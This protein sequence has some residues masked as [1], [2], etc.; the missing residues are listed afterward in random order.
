MGSMDLPIKINTPETNL[1]NLTF[2]IGSVDGISRWAAGLPMANTGESARQLYFAIGEINQWAA[3]PDLRM[4]V[5]EVLRP[6]IYSICTQLG[7]HFLQSSISL[8]Q[9]QVKI[10]KLAQ[11]LLTQLTTG[12]KLVVARGI[13]LSKQTN[14][15]LKFMPLAVHR[16]MTDLSQSILVN[17]QLYLRA[18]ETAWLELNQLYL[19]AEAN[20]WLDN[21]IID[22]QT[23]YLSSTTIRSAFIRAHL[24]AAAKP[25]N[26]RQQD[27]NH[28]FNALEL[29][30][31]LCKIEPADSEDSLFIVNLYRDRPATF[32]Q[33]LTDDQKALFRGINTK[34]LVIALK[35][36]LAD[37]QEEIGITIPKLMNENLINHVIHSWGVHAQRSFRRTDSSGPLKLCLGLMSI[38]YH[39]AKENNFEKVLMSLQV[40]HSFEQEDYSSSPNFSGPDD[41]WGQAFDSGPSTVVAGARLDF[42]S[43]RETAASESSKYPVFQAAINNSSPGGYSVTWQGEPPTTL[44]AGE[45]LGVQEPRVKHWAIGVVRWIS[46]SNNQETKLG[47]ELLSP[48]AEAGAIQ[49][50]QKTGRNGAMLRTLMLPEIKAIAQPASILAPHLPFKT[51]NKVNLLFD[52]LH[53][54]FQLIK[55]LASTNSFNQFQFRQLGVMPESATTQTKLSNI[56][57]DFD[58]LWDKL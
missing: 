2:C 18:D 10:A 58:A 7:K 26:L 8:N 56:E 28:L 57:D 49:L 21:K 47:I 13:L 41:V 53:G 39:C 1:K 19:L 52:E 25:N 55:R 50:L 45:L 32:R 14:Q 12:Y 36:Y 43:G 6:Y 33:Q 51:G 20:Q 16:A 22:K 31:N 24:L 4:Q 46:R 37:P 29:W 48:R 54:R 27:L 44:Q 30:T 38:H 17:Y 15:Q 23:E 42:V 5:L 40:K 11:S 34:D 9:K 35:K 3:K